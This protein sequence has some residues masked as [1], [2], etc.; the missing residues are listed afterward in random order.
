MSA[1]VTFE[2]NQLS[3]YILP[4]PINR[5]MTFNDTM[6]TLEHIRDSTRMSSEFYVEAVAFQQVAIEEME[7]RGFAVTA[8]RP[9]KDKRAR[10]RVA[11]RYI[12]LGVVKFP[13]TGCEQLLTQLLG[14]G[15]ERFDDLTDSIVY[16]I[17]GLIRDNSEIPDIKYI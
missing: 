17:L 4:H 8:M 14:F 3:I 9:M 10:L 5:R 16:L 11:A 6:V 2:N 15:I 13:R 1:E 7:R 12:K